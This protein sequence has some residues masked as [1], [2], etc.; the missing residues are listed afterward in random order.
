MTQ[1][2]IKSFKKI[3]IFF[4]M[5]I[6]LLVHI[7]NVF[8]IFTTFALLKNVMLRS[9]IIAHVI[10]RSFCSLIYGHGHIM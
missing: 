8:N 4:Y 9:D 7:I 1:I 6:F 10:N 5:V 2:V 3:T